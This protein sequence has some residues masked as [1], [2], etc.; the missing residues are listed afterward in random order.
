GLHYLAADADT[1]VIVLISKPPDEAIATKLLAAALSAGKPVVVD[2]IGFAPPTARIGNLHF[3]AGLDQA[4]KLAIDLAKLPI[5]KVAPP[6][7]RTGFLR[8]LFAGG[9]LAYEVLNGLQLFLAPIYSNI[10]IRPGQALANPL[11]SLAHTILDLGEDEFTLGRL[12]PMLDND[13]RL[14]RMKQ[15]AA[16]SEVGMILLDVVLGEG[17]HPDPAGELAPAISTHRKA[18]KDIEFVA[19]VIGTDQDP[20]QVDEQIRGLTKAGATVFRDLAGTIGYVVSRLVHRK[21]AG[22]PVAKFPEPLSAINVGVE[23]F[24]VSLKT[25]GV[26]AVHVDWRPPAAGNEDLMDLLQKMKA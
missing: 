7:P 25:Q 9:T 6:K 12:H 11:N 21:S 5:E 18:R 16:D 1:K 15:E 19:L 10:P 24:Y 2:F 3:A 22:S 8:G 17:A 23:S 13:L 26:D 14:R 4:A 20:Q